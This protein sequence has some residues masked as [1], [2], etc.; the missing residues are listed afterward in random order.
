MLQKYNCTSKDNNVFQY[1]DHNET[2]IALWTAGIYNN[3][4][5]TATQLRQHEH[6]K[7]IDFWKLLSRKYDIVR[8]LELENFYSL[9][10]PF[11]DEKLIFKDDT[12][13][14]F[15]RK[16]NKNILNSIDENIIKT[17]SEA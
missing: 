2:Y 12:K 9:D 4:S 16:N 1:S 7:D 10:F 13:Y 17:F 15:L 11:S 3:K 14:T 8:E 6:F 5:A